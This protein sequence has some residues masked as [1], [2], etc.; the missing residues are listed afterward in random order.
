M[1]DLV[2]AEN[3]EQV[4]ASWNTSQGERAMSIP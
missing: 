1:E 4:A 2:A 3:A